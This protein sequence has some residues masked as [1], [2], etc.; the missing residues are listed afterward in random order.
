M[1]PATHKAPAALDPSDTPE[2]AADAASRAGRRRRMLV[3]PAVIVLVAGVTWWWGKLTE[4]QRHTALFD[5]T[6]ALVQG[7]MRQTD[8]PSTSMRLRWANPAMESI[9][10]AGLADFAAEPARP[11][12]KVRSDLI[13][14]DNT[15]PVEI[16]AGTASIVLLIRPTDDLDIGVI[17]SVA[18]HQ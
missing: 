10:L 11:T 16:T 15:T 18:R 5:A 1:T 12:I 8:T 7:H 6:T 2:L 9:F 14:A 17:Q 3:M 13:E 4:D